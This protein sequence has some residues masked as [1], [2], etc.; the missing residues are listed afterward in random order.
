MGLFLSVKFCSSELE[1]VLATFLYSSNMTT[2]MA[3][4]VNESMSI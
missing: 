4:S 1:F 2:H 3:A